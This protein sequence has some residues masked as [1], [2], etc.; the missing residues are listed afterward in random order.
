MPQQLELPLWKPREATPEEV[1]Q[2]FVE[3]LK[4][5][6]DKSLQYVVMASIIQA[7]CLGFMFSMF[8]VIDKLV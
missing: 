8:W 7:C 3:E 5:Q 1:Q 4:P 2:W 6:A